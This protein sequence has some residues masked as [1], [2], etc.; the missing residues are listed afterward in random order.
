MQN[1]LPSG[2]AR[3]TQVWVALADVDVPGAQAQRPLDLGGL[4]VGPQV[5]VEP[6]LDGLA[7]RDGQEEEVGPGAELE[8]V[9][10]VVAGFGLQ[11]P[12]EQRC[13]ELADAFGVIAVDHSGLETQSH[14]W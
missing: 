4:V 8:P 7:L 13:P 2:S 14:G 1:S 5:E 12:V 6:V 11:G 3:T 9:L 10:R